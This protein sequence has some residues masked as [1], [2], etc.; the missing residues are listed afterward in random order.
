M[1]RKLRIPLR[2]QEASKGCSSRMMG[3]GTEEQNFG[4]RGYRGA[5]QEE[6]V[7]AAFGKKRPTK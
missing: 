7:V 2:H 6:R 1:T 3:D 4:E 5:H